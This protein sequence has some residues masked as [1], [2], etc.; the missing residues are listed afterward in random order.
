M[1]VL[2]WLGRLYGALVDWVVPGADVEAGA[3]VVEACRESFLCGPSAPAGVKVR[4]AH[5]E[6]VASLTAADLTA[7]PQDWNGEQLADGSQA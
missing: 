6:H 1:I 2:R 4:A 5:S 7:P 3:A